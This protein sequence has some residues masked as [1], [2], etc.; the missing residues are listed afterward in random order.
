MLGELY[1]PKGLA[2]E[3][4]QAV[5]EVEKPHATNVGYGCTGGCSYCY[6]P[7]AFHKK[8]WS[9]VQRPKIPPVQLLRK[10]LKKG[11][12]PQ[13]IFMSFATDPFIKKNVGNTYQLLQ[14]LDERKIPFAVST[15]QVMP[16]RFTPRK[17]K[18]FR[19]GKTIVSI[20]KEFR[21]KHEKFSATI[22][23]RIKD[24]ET[25]KARGIY[26]WDSMEP[27]PVPKIHKQ[28]II[29]VLESL[30]FL[31]FIIFGKW[32]YDERANDLEAREFYL[33]II[34]QFVD[35]CKSN[36]IRYHVKSDTLQFAGLDPA[37]TLSNS[38]S[39]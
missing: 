37:W 23:R 33:E 25:D 31:D 27:Y 15:K 13:A 12:K 22:D 36:K 34:P 10:Q 32:N 18:T 30:K 7:R 29:K 3:Q 1:E 8:D 14:F 38:L 21:K 39:F 2:L 5:L 26:V 19:H 4:A 20:D 11:L 6:G 24:L 17:L 28:D 35:W 16:A 9:R